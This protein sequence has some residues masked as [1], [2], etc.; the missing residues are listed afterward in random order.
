MFKLKHEHYENLL[1]AF[2]I[3]FSPII[4]PLWILHAIVVNYFPCSFFGKF[5]EYAHCEE[6]R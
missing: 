2:V 4:L 5:T 1:I 6:D 3:L